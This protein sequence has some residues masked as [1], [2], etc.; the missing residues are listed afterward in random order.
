MIGPMD[1]GL[2]LRHALRRL[3]RSQGFSAIIVTTLAV[4]IGGATTLF[5]VVDSVLWRPLPFP[6]PEQLV[7]VFETKQELSAERTGIGSGNLIEW[8]KRSQSFSAIGGWYVMGRTLQNQSDVNAVRAAMVT[9]GFFSTLN[10]RAALGRTPSPEETARS[11]YNG[12]A[13]PAGTGLVTV[14]S[15][16]LWQAR[17]GGD[18]GVLGRTVLIDRKPFEIIG[19]MPADFTFPSSDVA[20]WL[21]WGFR[22]NPPK[23]QRYVK[24]LARLRVGTSLGSAQGELQSIAAQLA[25]EFPASNKGWSVA[26]SPLQ[27]EVVGNSGATLWLLFAAVCCVWLIGCA[28]VAHLQWIRAAQQKQQTAVRVA[29]GASTRR[30]FVQFGTEG[31]LL[32]GAGGALGALLAFLAVYALRLAQPAQLPRATEV[33]VHGTALLFALGTSLV[34]GLATGLAPALGWRRGHL[35]VSLREGGR[36]GTGGKGSLRT[37]NMLVIG[38]VAAAAMLL[39]LAGLLGRSLMQLLA[40]DPGYGYRNVLV[41]PMFLDNNQ[42]N[43]GDK[44]RAYFAELMGKLGALPGVISVGGATALPA[45]PLGPDFERPVWPEGAQPAPSEA[46]RADVR[47]VTPDYFRT[48]QIPL[49]RGRAFGPEDSPEAPRAVI[50]N[51]MLAARVWPGEDAVGKHLVVDYSTAGIYSLQVVGVVRNVRFYG[52]RS[53]PR[54]EIFIPHAQRSYLIMNVAVRTQS[55]PR[56]LI[57]AVRRTVLEVDPGQPPQSIRPLAELV[58]ETVAQDRLATGLFA[59]FSG[60]ALFLAMLGIYGVTAY[61]AAQRTNEIGIRIALGARPAGIA[62]M[63]IASGLLLA[64]VGGAAGLLLAAFTSRWVASLLFGI[65]TLDPTAYLAAGAA[66]A[67]VTVAACWI[68]ARRAA[69]VNPIEALRHT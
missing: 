36:G 31:A 39:V 30:L 48:L 24:G 46:M 5:S 61:R 37:R 38:E 35:A 16:G 29:L 47:M 43:S 41:L 45:S 50:V 55:D 51:E 20:V 34:A 25:Q 7:R 60:T 28:N 17:F 42:Y 54:A 11:L 64:V 27:K 4:G 14:I 65:T 10:V 13:A 53:Q 26:L 15:Y 66:I 6:E 19:V 21:P 32:A 59:A 9:E 23:D 33:S 18:P 49:L 1:L 22:E 2:E 40:V 68:P 58:S 3:R 67:A 62:R 12:A 52:L 8:R 44:V 56:A 63:V 69:R 57:A